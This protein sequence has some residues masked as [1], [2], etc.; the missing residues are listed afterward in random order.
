MY[1][2]P[3]IARMGDCNAGRYR[4]NS[5]Q[6]NDPSARLPIPSVENNIAY[7]LSIIFQPHIHITEAR[8]RQL[9]SYI[10]QGHRSRR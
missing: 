9:S 6:L 2:I 3:N 4:V 10:S 8:S 7:Q 5:L 1:A